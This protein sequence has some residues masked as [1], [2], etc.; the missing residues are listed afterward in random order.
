MEPSR[1]FQ[2]SVTSSSNVWKYIDRA[3]DAT[4]DAGTPEISVAS[5]ASKLRS[6]SL[7][8]EKMLSTRR[9]TRWVS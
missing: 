3:V 6:C 2:S 7:R 5:A 9:A 8:D 4:E 1:R